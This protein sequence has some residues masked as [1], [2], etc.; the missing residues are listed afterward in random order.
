MRGK[1][2]DDFSCVLDAPILPS[3]GKILRALRAKGKEGV[4]VASMTDWER[5]NFVVVC[6]TR[7]ASEYRSSDASR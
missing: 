4:A 1:E 6:K 5:L 3:A 7:A 2:D